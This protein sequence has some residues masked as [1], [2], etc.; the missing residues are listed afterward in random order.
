MFLL[1]KDR[2]QTVKGMAAPHTG[3]PYLGKAPSPGIE[4][5]RS[6]VETPTG[7]RPTIETDAVTCILRVSG[8][9]PPELWNRLGNRLLP[10]LRQGQSLKLGVDFTLQVSATEAAHLQAE[11]RQALGDLNLL[12]AVQIHIEPPS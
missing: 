2:A 11:L 4:A 6:E 8:N 10:K 1:R 5:G 3:E 9:V 12:G 7:A